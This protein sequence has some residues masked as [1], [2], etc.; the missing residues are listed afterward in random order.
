MTLYTSHCPKC[1]ILERILIDKKVDFIKEDNERIYLPIAESNN[2]MSMP[3]AEISGNILNTKE[4]Q[5][6]ITSI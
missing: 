2:I 3:F 4:L 6:Y 1:K 5:T